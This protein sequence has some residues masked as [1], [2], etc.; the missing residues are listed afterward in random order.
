MHELLAPTLKLKKDLI[1]REFAGMARE[2][3]PLEALL[4]TERCL[5]A[6]IRARLTDGVAEFLLSLHDAQPDFGV[7][8][9]PQAAEL[10]AVRWK[11]LNLETL[12]RVNPTKH[13]MQRDLLKKL[14]S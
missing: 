7:I 14:L 4:E 8:G 9:L 13:A 11:L 6:D 5:H 10:P 3:V 12:K 1:Y 2:P